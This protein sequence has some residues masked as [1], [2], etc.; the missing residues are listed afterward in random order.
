MSFCSESMAYC[1]RR[2]QRAQEQGQPYASD[3]LLTC[4]RPH[5][6]SSM[7]EGAR[8]RASS[9]CTR[10]VF[11]SCT[12]AQIECS[13]GMTTGILMFQLDPIPV[14]SWECPATINARE[15]IHIGK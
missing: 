5:P 10:N 4:R 12:A 13:M 14:K 15:A 8:P 7:I 9:L 6:S 11:P 3:L 2:G 1:E